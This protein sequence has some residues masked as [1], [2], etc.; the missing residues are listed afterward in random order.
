MV[1]QER[2]I[3]NKMGNVPT[4]EREYLDLKRQQEIL[5]GVYLVLLQK[6]EEIALSL[7]SD[8]DRG[9]LTDPAYVKKAP[10]GPR[11][12]YAALFM[13]AFTLIVPIGYLFFKARII[14]LIEEYKKSI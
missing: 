8:R 14:E 7:G 3:L 12:L 1:T 11:K 5:Q 2:E 4:Y 10:I 13:I 6:R 9:F